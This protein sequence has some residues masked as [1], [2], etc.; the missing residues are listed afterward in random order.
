MMKRVL[1][2]SMFCAAVMLAAGTAAAGD[3]WIGSWKLDAAKS[4][5]ATG[6]VRAQTLKFEAA[7]DGNITLTS[8]GI[9]ADGK[10][11]HGT[12]TAK[13]DGTDAPWAGNA[14]ADTASP[15]RVDDNTYENTW[16]KGGKVTVTAK[17]VVSKDGKAM[18]VTQ[19]GTDGKGAKFTSVAVYNRQ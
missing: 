2:S 10:P 19:S 9:D 11:M 7:A 3:N 16:K 8:D 6:G 13:F 4:K 1:L 15:K 18:T 12:Y 14:L 17:V 5:E